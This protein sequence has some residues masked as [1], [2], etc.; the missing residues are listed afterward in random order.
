MI[1]PP[2]VA[3][4]FSKGITFVGFLRRDPP[5][6]AGHILARSK[7]RRNASLS[8]LPRMQESKKLNAVCY[9]VNKYIW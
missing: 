8:I 3:G 6:E 2:P 9:P 4:F 1:A 5:P 7:L